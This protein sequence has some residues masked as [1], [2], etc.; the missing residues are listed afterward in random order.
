MGEIPRDIPEQEMFSTNAEKSEF[1]PAIRFDPA[2]KAAVEHMENYDESLESEMP[3]AL[4]ILLDEYSETLEVLKNENI[5]PVMRT[6]LNS[7]LNGLRHKIRES[8]EFDYKLD[9]ELA[10]AVNR[11]LRLRVQADTLLTTHPIRETQE[12]I[13]ATTPEA[14]QFHECRR[15]MLLAGTLFKRTKAEVAHVSTAEQPVELNRLEGLELRLL[16]ATEALSAST[17][18][19]KHPEKVSLEIWQST[20]VKLQDVFEEIL[21][22][23]REIHQ[24]VTQRTGLTDRP[25]QH[26]NRPE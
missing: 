9:R 19:T 24:R 4:K 25:P 21:L 18:D 11:E 26:S 20:L 3:E 8:E 13:D 5:D 2:V 10:G 23:N 16:G 14:E 22:A 6:Q 1:G 17:F 12:P 15:V 7:Q